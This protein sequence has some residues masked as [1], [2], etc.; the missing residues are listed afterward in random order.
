[1]TG[2]EVHHPGVID[3]IR[4]AVNFSLFAALFVWGFGGPIRDYFR[5]RTAKIREALEAGAKAKRE[6]ETLRAELERD[7]ADL[8]ATRAKMVAEFRETAEL[9]RQ[10]LFRK[11]RQAA[12]RIRSEA[13]IAA[14][15]EASAARAELSELVVRKV[16]DEAN[17]L[18]RGAI[19][20]DDQRRFVEEFVQSARTL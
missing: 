19:T 13:K 14:E 17:R 16:V 9:E 4:P 1:M 8:P 6:A 10:L 3:L 15:Q 7:T 5:E 12:D 20:A 11:S 18:V 2:H